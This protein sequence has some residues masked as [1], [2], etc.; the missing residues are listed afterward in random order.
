MHVIA[1][2]SSVRRRR[3]HEHYH[4]TRIYRPKPDRMLAKESRVVD[5]APVPGWMDGCFDGPEG[6]AVAP[7]G[8]ESEVTAAE[9]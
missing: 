2:M 5:A 8:L 3:E 1:D 9:V 6:V 7:T 4:V